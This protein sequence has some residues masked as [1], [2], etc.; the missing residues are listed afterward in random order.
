MSKRQGKFRHIYGDPAKPERQF[1][2]IKN[3]LT[4]GEGSYV[5]ANARFFAVSKSG[6]GGPVYIRKLDDYGRF[7]PNTPMISVSNGKTWDMDFH[8]F[9]PNMIATAS[10]DTK[11]YVTQ[12]PM[13]GLTE[14]ITDPTVTLQGH[15][16]KVQLA[17]F[18]PSANSILATGSFDRSVRVWNIETSS[19]VSTFD[20]FSDNVY[21]ME[22]NQNGSLLA[23]TGKDK[24]LR[25]F[26]PRQTEEAQCVSAFDGAKSSKVFW[27]PRFNWV[28]GTGTNKGAKRQLRLWDMRKLDD[29]PIFSNNLD[30][31]SSTLMPHFDNDNGVLYLFG[32]GEGSV[33]YFELVNDDKKVWTLGVFRKPEPQKGGGWV[34]KKGLDVWKCEVQ[35]FL[36]LTTKSIIPISFIVPRKAG[37]D[38]F[39]DDI[40]PD[41][42][43]GK[44]A[45]SASEWESGENKDPVRMSMD[46][47]TRKDNDDDDNTGF[48]K[49]ATYQELLQ[50]N[51]QLKKRVQELESKLGINS[52]DDEQ[53]EDDNTNDDNQ[54][55]EQQDDN[56]EQEE[57]NDE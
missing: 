40:F 53:K 44:P 38:V 23:C 32:K 11:A 9:I 57:N 1:L 2:E 48:Q 55:E 22:W 52:N 13:G 3:P 47:S 54:E 27:V 31:A 7:A 29:K 37:A 16:K 25:I 12:F 4:S 26:D 49:K 20:Q 24:K 10:D 41:C 21:S 14:N 45:L 51:E 42:L 34:P 28:G 15:G 8:P 18:N 6:G 46:P 36:K 56:N 30:Q 50:E 43:A 39:Q 5:A 35:R 19:C 33:S 17:K